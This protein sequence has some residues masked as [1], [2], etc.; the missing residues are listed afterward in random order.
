MIIYGAVLSANADTGDTLLSQI[1]H[2]ITTK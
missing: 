2:I 1:F